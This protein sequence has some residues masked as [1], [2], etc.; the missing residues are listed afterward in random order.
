MKQTAVQWLWDISQ[1][2]ELNKFDWEKALEMESEIWH[3]MKF[4]SIW[5]DDNGKVMA[6]HPAEESQAIPELSDEEIIKWAYGKQYDPND[7]TQSSFVEGMKA[8]REQIKS[9]Q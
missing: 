1:D 7:E 2:R 4:K 5:I 6:L 9:K 3:K 8:Y